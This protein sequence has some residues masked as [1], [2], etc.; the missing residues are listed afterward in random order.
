MANRNPNMSGL[1][2]F[3]KQTKR[4]RT[5]NGRKGGKRSGEVRA[6]KKLQRE[7][8]AEILNA[9]APAKTVNRLA[10]VL[11]DAGDVTNEAAILA[12]VVKMARDKGSLQA[13]VFIRDTLGQS[14]A[15]K[16]DHTSGGQPLCAAIVPDKKS[17]D[18]W[19]KA[20]NDE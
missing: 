15:S 12:S 17:L 9:A 2:P 14:P 1:R 18:D 3:D 4:E 16:I 10:D 11:G 13:A 20:Q 6:R 5:K 7:I 19:V 8:L